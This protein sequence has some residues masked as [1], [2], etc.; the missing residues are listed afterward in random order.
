[1]GGGSARAPRHL[2]VGSHHYTRALFT[3]AGYE[4]DGRIEAVPPPR[5]IAIDGPAGSGKSVIGLWL[6]AQLGYAYLDTGALY[7]AIAWLALREGTSVEDGPALAGLARRF[8][9]AVNPPG[10][11]DRARG[12]T[13]AI[14]GQRV[15]EQLFSPE[16]NDAVSPVAAHPAVRAAVLPLQRAIASRGDVVMVGR[17]IGTV[18]MPDAEL[19][20]YLDASAEERARRRWAEEHQ[21]GRQRPY[22][23]VLAD[24][25]QRDRIDSSR[26]TAPLRAADD[27][28]LLNTEGLALEE[29]KSRVRAVLAAPRPR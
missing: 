7:R 22:A 12:Y 8:A 28:V 24:V 6:A 23:D 2:G 25:Q 16:V 11:A 5:T 27:A 18:V 13:L 20:L 19:K 26:A 9:I 3:R 17:D 21:R 15:T 29:T 14:D 4:R 10:E 1:M